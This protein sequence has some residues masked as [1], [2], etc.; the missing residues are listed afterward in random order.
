MHNLYQRVEE[1]VLRANSGL[2]DA[3]KASLDD[4]ADTISSLIQ[5]DGYANLN[6]ICT[7]NS[8]R[9]HLAQVWAQICAAYH[10]VNDVICYSGGTEA[11]A[12]YRTVIA[13]LESQGI[14]A[15]QLS[16]GANA[17][18]ALRFDEVSIPIVAYS[19][20]YSDDFNPNKNFIAVMVCS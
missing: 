2:D 7:H 4:L 8:R 12:V 18:Y 15:S 9:S 13:T 17:V 20:K 1:K 6:F 3:R 11:T 14:L 19:K 10:N 16:Q 5:S